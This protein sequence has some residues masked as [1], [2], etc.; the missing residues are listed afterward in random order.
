MTIADG[1]IVSEVI[2]KEI[3][4]AGGHL[5]SAR[6]YTSEVELI[7]RVLVQA[8][9]NLL[10]VAAKALLASEPDLTV[11]D[12]S[13]APTKPITAGGDPF[14]PPDVVVCGECDVSAVLAAM[15]TATA[16]RPPIVA[17]LPAPTY[18]LIGKALRSGAAGLQCVTC[19]LSELP[20]A[21]IAIGHGA[22][23]WFAPC[24]AACIA[25]HL[26]G[27]GPR[28]DDHGLTPREALI[29][30]LMA[31]GATNADIADQLHL[32]VRTVKHHISS[33]FR[34]LGARNRSEAVALAYRL[35][36]VV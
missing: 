4:E 14:D 10:R 18:D 21:V 6:S 20:A 15:T 30:E 36:L 24:I 26:S 32:D 35:G 12:A 27:R 17:L 29:L 13:V 34:K 11:S 7:M 28:A 9:D 5:F 3:E 33:I 2:Q 8:S 16:V 1:G 31:S 25:A 19:H 22:Q 23:A